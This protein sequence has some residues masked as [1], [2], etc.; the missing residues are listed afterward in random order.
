MTHKLIVAKPGFNA[1]TETN[2]NNLTFSSDYKTLK[3][4][5]SG[6]TTISVPGSGSAINTDYDIFTHNLGYYPFFTAFIHNPAFTQ[7]YSLPYQASGVG[8]Y[9]YFTGHTTTSKLIL[10]IKMSSNASLF[11]LTV[12]YKIYKNNLGL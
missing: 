8:T 4:Y 11:N 12:Y 1:L 3:Y 7:Y 2:P 6:S 5:K 9:V 10:N